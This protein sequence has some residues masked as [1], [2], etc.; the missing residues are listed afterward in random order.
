MVLPAMHGKVSADWLREKEG[1]I[2]S[3]LEKINCSFRSWLSSNKDEGYGV[4][5]EL[6]KQKARRAKNDGML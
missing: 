3:A 4:M 6:V 1:E 5:E 2:K